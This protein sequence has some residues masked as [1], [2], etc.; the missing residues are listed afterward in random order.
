[1]WFRFQIAR[2]FFRGFIVE[3]V[4]EKDDELV[5]TAHA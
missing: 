2:R 5:V 4:V 1:M 3:Q